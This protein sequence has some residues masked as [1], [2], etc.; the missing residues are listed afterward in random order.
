MNKLISIIG[1]FF[2]L[3]CGSTPSPRQAEL[4]V[5]YEGVEVHRAGSKYASIEEIHAKTGEKG[6]KYFIFSARWCKSCVFLERA[7]EQSGHSD[8]VTLID[9]DGQETGKLAAVLEIQNVPTMVVI[10]EN[11]N[12]TEKLVGP[13][14][15][16]MHMLI[17]VEKK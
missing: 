13:S 8:M 15:I 16:V 4:V 3:S 11:D 5:T 14:A 1:F 2:I 12:I 6:K 7:L 9:V 17:N 10:D